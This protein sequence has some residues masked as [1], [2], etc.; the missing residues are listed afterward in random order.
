MTTGSTPGLATF[1]IV[2][3]LWFASSGLEGV[4]HA[5]ENAYHSH[6]QP[7]NFVVARLQSLVLTILTAIGLLIA[8]VTIV[9]GP[10]IRDALEWLAQR[11][12]VD[13]SF[14]VIARYTFGLLLL[15]G[16]TLLLH[17]TLPTARLRLL[18]VLPGA[19]LSVLVWGVVAWAYSTYLRTLTRYNLHLRQPERHCADALLLLHLRRH[20]HF[21]RPVQRCVAAWSIDAWIRLTI[22]QR[23]PDRADQGAFGMTDATPLMAGK[24][25]LVMGIANERSLAWGIA[26]AARAQGAELAITYQG[27]ALMKRVKPLAEQLGASLVAAGRRHRQRQPRCPLR[28]HR[29]RPGGGSTSSSMPS[30]SPTRRRCAAAISRS[31]PRPSPR[32]C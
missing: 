24:K 1:G 19:L 11:Q 22:A 12:L 18:D 14:Y 17:L 8:I 16:V 26:R 2:L 20:F 15:L 10:F 23:G 3:T 27:E 6:R 28:E 32:P 25:G 9:G 21:W 7:R 29:R 5:L 4:R 31:R 30:A 13:Q